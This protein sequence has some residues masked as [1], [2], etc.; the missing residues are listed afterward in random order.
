MI[1]AIAYIYGYTHDIKTDIYLIIAG[2][3]AKEGLKKL[4]IEIGKTVTK[5]AINKKINREVMKKIWSVVGRKIITRSGKKSLTS[6]IKMVPLIG[7]P[8]GFVWDWSAAQF[9]GRKA[10]KYYSGKG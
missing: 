3:S 10:I 7:A 1:I 4:S 2:N 6:F 9:V 5:K 8:I